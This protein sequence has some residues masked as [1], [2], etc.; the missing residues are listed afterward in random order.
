MGWAAVVLNLLSAGCT[1]TPCRSWIYGPMESRYPILMLKLLSIPSS[2]YAC[3]WLRVWRGPFSHFPPSFP[4]HRINVCLLGQSIWTHAL[5][6]KAA[7]DVVDSIGSINISSM[8]HNMPPT[9]GGAH[10]SLCRRG[11][12]TFPICNMSKDSRWLLLRLAASGWQT[13]HLHLLGSWGWW[14]TCAEPHKTTSVCSLT[15]GRRIQRWHKLL[16]RTVNRLT[17]RRWSC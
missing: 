1:K 11:T 12:Q 9:R 10:L 3:K 17:E 15:S 2:N 16:W 13:A 5:C 8:L 14:R 7:V 6:S 4:S